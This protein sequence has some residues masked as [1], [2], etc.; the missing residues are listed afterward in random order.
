MKLLKGTDVSSCKKAT[1]ISRA[2]AAKEAKKV[3][4]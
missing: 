4:G 3:W 2:M 1:Y